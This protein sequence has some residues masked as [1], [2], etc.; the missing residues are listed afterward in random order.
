MLRRA[1]DAAAHFRLNAFARLC[2]DRPLFSIDEIKKAFTIYEALYA[3]GEPPHLLTNHLFNQQAPGLTTEII[4]TSL[5]TELSNTDLDL[6]DREHITR[7][8][9]THKINYSIVS[10]PQEHSK[11]IS[12]RWSVDTQDDYNNLSY[13]FS[14]N[15][16][17]GLAI[18]EAIGILSNHQN[19]L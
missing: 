2:G 15:A 5:L 17:V 14:R 9:Y 8:I 18:E 7:Y 11:T 19:S 12:Y 16:S 4:D 6:M 3:I 10:L 13:L 1:A